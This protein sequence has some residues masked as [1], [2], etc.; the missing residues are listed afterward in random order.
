MFEHFVLTRF[1]IRF[2]YN[3]FSREWSRKRMKLMKSNLL[4]CLKKQTNKNFRHLVFFDIDSKNYL[5]DEIDDLVKEYKIEPCYLDDFYSPEWV[6]D[7]VTS[8]L[9]PSTEYVLT[10]RAD[11]DDGLS[12]DFIKNIQSC[13]NK[14]DYE[15]IIFDNGIMINNYPSYCYYD[16][17]QKNNVFQT[18]IQ[19]VNGS[20]PLITP[21]TFNHTQVELTEPVKHVILNKPM[22]AIVC[23]DS[24]LATTMRRNVFLKTDLDVVYDDIPIENEWITIPKK[25]KESEDDIYNH[26]TNSHKFMDIGKIGYILYNLSNCGYGPGVMVNDSDDYKLAM[27]MGLGTKASRREI[28]YDVPDEITDFVDKLEALSL[29]KYIEIIDINNYQWIRNI[30]VLTI[31]KNRNIQKRFEFWNKYIIPGGYIVIESKSA[32]SE[33]FKN[34]LRNEFRIVEIET[35]CDTAVF[36]KI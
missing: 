4:A 36:I 18:L 17:T 9:S 21:H 14:Q 16:R 24:N 10:T 2:D 35:N 13:F 27:W 3:V 31:G 28:V 11:T 29:N 12:I 23:H 1:N 25:L 30:R 26:I 20:K 7:Q 5:K 8:R 34:K 15:F 33:D 32:I 6:T 22:W 19:K